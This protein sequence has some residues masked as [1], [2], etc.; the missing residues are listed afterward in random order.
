MRLELK[1]AQLEPRYYCE[2]VRLEL[3]LAHLKPHYNYELVRLEL[4]LALLEPHLL[5]STCE[6]RAVVGSAR[7]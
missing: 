5:L 4:K 7:A 6:A 3:K 2:L 1:L